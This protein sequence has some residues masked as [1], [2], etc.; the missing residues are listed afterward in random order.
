MGPTRPQSREALREYNN[1]FKADANK[2]IGYLKTY[3]MWKPEVD[4]AEYWENPEHR[5]DVQDLYNYLRWVYQG[6]PKQAD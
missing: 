6:F 1:R 4:S 2:L 3:D 5:K